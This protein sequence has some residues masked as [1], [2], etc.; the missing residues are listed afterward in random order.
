MS[1][2]GDKVLETKLKKIQEVAE[3]Y[4]ERTVRNACENVVRPE[5]KMLCP[6]NYGEL[7]GS[8]RTATKK[9]EEGGAIGEVYTNK[10]Y[11][12]YVEFGTGPV[13]EKNHNGISPF[14]DVAYSQKGWYIPSDAISSEDAERYHFPKIEGKDMEFY[15]TQGQPAQPF[16]YPA[17]HNN[18]ERVTKNMNNYIQ[19][20]MREAV[21]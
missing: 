2:L 9:L 10:K 1:V 4:M 21:K 5:A 16:L 3:T 6:V 20:K 12:I 11:A 8:I 13:G 7:R 15:Y 18:H 14:V 19:R 17:L